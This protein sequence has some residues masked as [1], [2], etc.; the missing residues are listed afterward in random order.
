MR[1][2]EVPC[3][4]HRRN[5]KVSQSCRDGRNQEKEHHDNTMHGEQLVISVV[6]EASAGRKQVHSHHH[7]ERAA[8]KEERRDREEIKEC[9]ALVIRCK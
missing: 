7:S 2:G 5:Q 3:T 4:D 8:D 9:D 6:R 1:K